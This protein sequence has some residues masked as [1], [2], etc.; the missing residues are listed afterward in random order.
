MK[1]APRA[2]GDC[3]E[4]AV[5]ILQDTYD[6]YKF[7]TKAISSNNQKYECVF[8]QWEKEADSEKFTWAEIIKVLKEIKNKRLAKQLQENYLSP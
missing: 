4:F 2:Q 1:V 7:E 6:T 5:Y 8:R 3:D